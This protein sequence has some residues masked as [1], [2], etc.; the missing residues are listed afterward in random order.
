MTK[1]VRVEW[2]QSHVKNARGILFL[3]N[4][5]LAKKESFSHCLSGNPI[6]DGD[7]FSPQTSCRCLL[8]SF[9]SQLL[10]RWQKKFPDFSTVSAAVWQT[11]WWGWRRIVAL[12][13]HP[14]ATC[15]LAQVGRLRL[16]ACLLW[17]RRSRCMVL[18]LPSKRS[19][20]QRIR[21]S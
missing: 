6:P 10:G 20:S 13:Q 21:M 15:V 17:L 19:C 12:W 9:D 1:R 8:S 16:D 3:L 2:L 14:P 5:L 7:T 4:K 18:Y 11:F